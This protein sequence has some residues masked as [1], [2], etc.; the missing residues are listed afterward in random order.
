MAQRS[1]QKPIAIL[2]VRQGCASPFLF[3]HNRAYG[4]VVSGS[5]LCVKKIAGA[6]S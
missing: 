2:E 1:R 6:S 5:R 3:D 4:S